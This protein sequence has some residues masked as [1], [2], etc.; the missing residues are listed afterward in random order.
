[1]FIFFFCFN[2]KAATC[3]FPG[4][5]HQPWAQLCSAQL[6]PAQNCTK[7]KPHPSWR[8]NNCHW[9]GCTNTQTGNAEPDVERSQGRGEDRTSSAI[10]Y[11]TE[12]IPGRYSCGL[13]SHRAAYQAASQA[14]HV[15]SAR[16][17]LASLHTALGPHSLTKHRLCPGQS[18]PKCALRTLLIAFTQK[19]KCSPHFK[20]EIWLKQIWFPT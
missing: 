2:G 13:I 4:L 16:Q 7:I 19:S 11:P 1:M 18:H 10:T 20:R 14:E 5:L 8:D 17:S 9:Q 3:Q 15:A 6:S 12:D